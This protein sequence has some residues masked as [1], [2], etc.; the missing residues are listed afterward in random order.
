LEYLLPYVDRVHVLLTDYGSPGRNITQ[1]SF[2]RV[3]ILRENIQY[4]E[5]RIQISAEGPIQ[6]KDVA[7]LTK[8]GVDRI[9][10]D[11]TS[12]FAPGDVEN[13]TQEF[14]EACKAEVQT[15]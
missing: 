1:A 11:N 12:I 4:H 6:A 7:I 3:K 5:Y 8:F 13:C 9:V 14:L 2:D 15:V 10:L